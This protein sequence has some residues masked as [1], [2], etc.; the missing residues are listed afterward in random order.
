MLYAQRSKGVS[1]TRHHIPSSNFIVLCSSTVVLQSKTHVYVLLHREEFEPSTSLVRTKTNGQQ[2]TFEHHISRLFFFQFNKILHQH[3]TKLVDA[4]QCSALTP[5]R[6]T[7]VHPRPLVS[8][9][10]GGL[11]MDIRAPFEGLPRPF[12][13]RGLK[14]TGE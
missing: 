11:E 13:L 9:P 14:V 1:K 2:P 7:M 8:N 4:A 6:F 10:N 5:S 3:F 12:E